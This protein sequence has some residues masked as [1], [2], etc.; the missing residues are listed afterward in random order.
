MNIGSGWESDSCRITM[1]NAVHTSD[2]LSE[3]FAAD[4]TVLQGSGSAGYVVEFAD[5]PG[6]YYSGDTGV[7]GDK[8]LI[9]DLYKPDVAILSVGRKYNMGVREGTYAAGL[10]LPDVVIPI[11]HGTFPNQVVDLGRLAE[12]M[13]AQSPETTLV[14]LIPGETYTCENKK[15]YVS[16]ISRTVS[17][18]SQ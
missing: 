3:E 9:R 15:N 8:A 18:A 1:V 4:G 11:R 12:N 6:I 7:F 2:L 13:K 5:G 14:W 10:L 16:R 17:I